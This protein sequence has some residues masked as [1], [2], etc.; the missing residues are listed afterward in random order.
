MSIERSFRFH[1]ELTTHHMSLIPKSFFYVNRPPTVFSNTQPH[2]SLT[3]HR[4]SVRRAGGP[5]LTPHI[6]RPP[7]FVYITAASPVS[8]EL[9]SFVI[10]AW[11]LLRSG[12]PAGTLR[13]PLLPLTLFAAHYFQRA[14]V[15]P[16][17]I[18]AD[19][20]EPAPYVLMATAFTAWNGMAQSAAAIQCPANGGD[21]SYAAVHLVGAAIFII[22]AAI[23]IDSDQRLLS[24]RRPGGPRYSVPRGG[25]FELVTA[26]NY[27]GEITEWWGYALVSWT[28]PALAFA[29]FTTVYLTGCACDLHNRNL[30]RFGDKYPKNRRRI[31]PLVF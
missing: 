12:L 7:P 24:L 30:A 18:S 5:V 2:L 23:N 22:G 14:L 27:L 6:P 31:I 15:Y 3:V 11:Y 25:V 17:R 29:L 13:P 9:P 19:S 20:T 1:T 10:P 8:Q 4:R 28:P 21:T 26:A 16:W